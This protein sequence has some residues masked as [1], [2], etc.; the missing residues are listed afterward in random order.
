MWG[1]ICILRCL[2]KLKT[3][4]KDKIHKLEISREGMNDNETGPPRHKS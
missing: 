2:V 1:Q 4:T 3:K